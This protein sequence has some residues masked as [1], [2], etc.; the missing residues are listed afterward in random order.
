MTFLFRLTFIKYLSS[1]EFGS[2]CES[3]RLSLQSSRERRVLQSACHGE[4][5]K[6]QQ[7]GHFSQTADNNLQ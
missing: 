6:G 5:S 1:L 3:R 2:H 4:Q 7:H